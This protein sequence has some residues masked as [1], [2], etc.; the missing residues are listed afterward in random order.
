MDKKLNVGFLGMKQLK[1]PVEN[2]KG[3]T[4]K[5]LVCSFCH[6]IVVMKLAMLDEYVR[7]YLL[8]FFFSMQYEIGKQLTLPGAYFT[9]TESNKDWTLQGCQLVGKMPAHY[10]KLPEVKPAP[11]SG[12]TH[13][14]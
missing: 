1:K 14:P 8:Y 5:E 7:E 4:I 9:R 12:T 10:G 3:D 2:S 6:S 13:D 11:P